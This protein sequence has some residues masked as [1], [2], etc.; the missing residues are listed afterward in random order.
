MTKP[1]RQR[2][3][4]GSFIKKA[5]RKV[6]KVIKSPLGKAALLGAGAYFAPMMWGQGAGFGGWGKGIGALRNKMFGAGARG[7]GKFLMGGP[8]VAGGSPTGG[9]LSKGWQG[10]KKFGLGKAAFLGAGALA[11]GLPYLGGDED[12]EVIDDW[13]VTPPSIAKLRKEAQDYYKSA[14]DYLGSPFM[15]PKESVMS[16]YYGSKEGGIVGLANGGQI[17]RAHV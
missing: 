7:A 6:K 2:Y 9:L 4:L 5:A 17:G 3:G 8:R 14:P 10:L 1:D 15:P 11:T 13:S 16:G 12:D